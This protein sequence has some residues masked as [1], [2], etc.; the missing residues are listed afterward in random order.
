MTN[1]AGGGNKPSGSMIVAAVVILLFGVLVVGG[2]LT[3]MQLPHPVTSQA[4]DTRLLY[5]ATLTISMVIYF[6]VTAGI[7]YAIFRF[8]QEERGVAGP[9]PRQQHTRAGL[10]GGAGGDPGGAVHPLVPSNE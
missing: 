5:E 4:K 3:A 8:P 6:G 2:S 7:I 10:D 1:S 9:V